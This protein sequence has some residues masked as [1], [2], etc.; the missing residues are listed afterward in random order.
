MY[1]EG[2][3]A[4]IEFI[5]RLKETG[6][7]LREIRRYALLRYEG[8]A[9][10]SERLRML[11]AHRDFIRGEIRKWEVNLAK[12]DKKIKIYEEGIARME[13]SDE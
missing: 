1:G 13:N 8:D 4:W 6:M 11:C 7:P 5:L 2:D 3:I 10:M 12:M 9:T